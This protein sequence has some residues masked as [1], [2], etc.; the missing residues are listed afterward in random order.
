[1]IDRSRIGSLRFLV[2]LLIVCL[3]L[4]GSGLIRSREVVAQSPRPILISEET[5]TRA[6]VFDSITKQREPFSPTHLAFG[7]DTR[8]RVMLFAKQLELQTGDAPSAVTVQ[9]EDGIHRVYFLPVEYVGPTPDHPWATAGTARRL[10][11]LLPSRQR[12]MSPD[13]PNMPPLQSPRERMPWQRC[14]RCDARR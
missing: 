3:F 5:S 7:G 13:C 6:L 2:A 12:S 8:T 1:M 9:A 4:L 14:T 11:W 10:R